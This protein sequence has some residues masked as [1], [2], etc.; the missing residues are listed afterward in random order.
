MNNSIDSCL[1]CQYI[2]IEVLEALSFVLYSGIRHLSV[3]PSWDFCQ[4]RLPEVC[5]N[6]CS[7]VWIISLSIYIS[8]WSSRLRFCR[9]ARIM[10]AVFW[11]CM[12]ILLDLHKQKKPVATISMFCLVRDYIVSTSGHINKAIPSSG[13]IQH[14]ARETD[15]GFMRVSE[16]LFNVHLL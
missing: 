16:T 7:T 6:R 13:R 9:D 12:C 4:L 15:V 11:I 8:I 14:G 3:C 5:S 10:Y 2:L 1:I